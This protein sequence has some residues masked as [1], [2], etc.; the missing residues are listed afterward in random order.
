MKTNELRRLR[1]RESFPNAS[2]SHQNLLGRGYTASHLRYDPPVMGA[3]PNPPSTPSNADHNALVE[4]AVAIVVDK[5]SGQNTGQI[6]PADEIAPTEAGW[7]APR[8]LISLRR[9]EQVLG[10]LW[11][12]PGG[13][14]ERGESPA[15]AVKRELLEEVGI[16][17]EPIHTLPTVEHTYAHARIRLH[18]MI[19]KHLAGTPSAIEV[20]AV[21]WVTIDQLNDYTFP[22]A[23]KPVLASFLHWLHTNA[24]APAR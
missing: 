9:A 3:G 1:P 17:A 8:V 20:D 21:R 5:L 19:C 14:I 2:T 4:V 7:A 24:Q 16:E 13:K 11:E 23:S 22:Q 18:P 6:E 10:G 12:L 15:D